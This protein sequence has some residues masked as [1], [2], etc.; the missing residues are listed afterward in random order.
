MVAVAGKCDVGAV[1]TEP[2]PH[3]SGNV[4]GIRSAAIGTAEIPLVVG[5][6]VFVPSV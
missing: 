4:D 3:G 5:D 1:G 2:D 6:H